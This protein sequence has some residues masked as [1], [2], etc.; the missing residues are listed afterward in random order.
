M[1]LYDREY[2]RRQ[3]DAGDRGGFTVLLW[4]IGLNVFCFLL[5]LGDHGLADALTLN[6]SPREF[7][8]WQILTYAFLHADFTHLLFNMWG[9]YLFGTLVTPHLGSRDFLLLYLAGALSGSL[10]YL[11]FNWGEP[12]GMLGASAAVCAVMMAAALCEPDRRFMMLFLPFFPLRTRTLVVCYTILEVIFQ[13]G[14]RPGDTVAHLAHLGGF[15]GGYLFIRIFCRR[16]IVWDPFSRAAAGG[17]FSG[18]GAWRGPRESAPP[19][20]PPAA[21]GNFNGGGPVSPAELDA[22]LDKI[23]RRGINSLSEY[24]LARLKRAREEMRGGSGR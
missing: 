11:G 13:F 2:Y 22:L 3:S 17:G 8:P 24:E 10:L 21:G 1:S 6:C 9:L 20:P 19:P 16:A 12:G 18:G 15:L 7:A 14:A 23:S 5:S 4:L